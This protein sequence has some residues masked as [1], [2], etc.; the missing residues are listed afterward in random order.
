MDAAV[1]FLA[2]VALASLWVARD[3]TAGLYAL[4]VLILQPAALYVVIRASGWPRRKLLRLGDAFVLGGLALATAGLYY[5]VTGYGE[6]AGGVRRLLVPFYDSPN[7][8]G[9][10][11][12]R[13]IPVAFCIAAFAAAGRRRLLHG[14]AA[15]VML[16]CTY[17]TFSRGAWLLGLPAAAVFIAVVRRRGSWAVVAGAA[18]LAL[19]GLLPVIGVAR[20]DPGG[21]TFASRLLLWQGAARMAAAHPL[22]GVGIGNFHTT[23]PQFMLPEAWREPLVYHAHNVALDFASMAGLIGLAAFAWVQVAFWRT[24]LHAYRSALG[25][26]ATALALGLMASMVYALAHGFVDTAYFLPDLALAFMLTV[27]MVAALD[28]NA[29]W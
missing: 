29:G 23:Y 24:G 2:F 25:A 6:T 5:Y 7:H 22:L 16:L 13:A 28:R 21:E 10:Y 8:I 11:L 1:A 15:A 17:L 18:A 14:F 26:D 27:G 19:I 20:F 12:G 4:R 3:V 9:L